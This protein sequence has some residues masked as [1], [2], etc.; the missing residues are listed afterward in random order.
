MHGDEGIQLNA[1]RSCRMDVTPI[2][3]LDMS[4][5]SYQTIYYLLKDEFGD[6]KFESYSWIGNIRT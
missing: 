5:S 3:A 6:L 2:G 1:V 4:G